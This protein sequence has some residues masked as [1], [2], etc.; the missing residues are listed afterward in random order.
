MIRFRCNCGKGLAVPD[1]AAGGD[2]QCP[3]CGRLQSVPELKDLPAI[4]ADGTW[5][6]ADDAAPTG[7]RRPIDVPSHYDPRGTDRHQSIEE[8][9]SVGLPR[10]APQKPRPKRY[11]PETGEL[12]CEF[13]LADPKD[14]TPPA[15]QSS[16]A[17]AA[18]AAVRSSAPASISASGFVATGPVRL[19]TPAFTPP[20]REPPPTLGYAAGRADYARLV[21]GQPPIPLNVRPVYWYTI[22]IELLQPANVLVLAFVFAIHIVIQ[23]LAVLTLFGMIPLII[24]AGWLWLVL[25]AHY[26]TVIDETGPER[27]DELPSVMRNLSPSEDFLRPLWGLVLALAICFGPAAAV[28]RRALI[29]ALDGLLYGAPAGGWSSPPSGAMASA[30][31]A[32]GIVGM[33]F[34]PAVLLTAATGGTYVNLAPHRTLGVIRAAPLKYAL[35]LA[36]LVAALISY[37]IALSAMGYLTLAIPSWV[38]STGRQKLVASMVGYPSL[39]IA[40]YC[41]HWF[42]WL[43]GKIHQEHLEEFGW[44]WQ[45]HISTR[46]D[47][48]KQLERQKVAQLMAERDEKVRQAAEQVQTRQPA[49]Q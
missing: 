22:P 8:I 12:I 38:P 37:P 23:L 14:W 17:P 35:T 21:A 10:E 16:E 45:R 19:E 2:V 48:I 27:R 36:V 29:W 3:S 4:E 5:R 40:V 34:F 6:F 41:A 46:H 7:L 42:A 11:D 39:F 1:G 44:V 28:S 24:L 31:L 43:L 30:G 13:D 18:P 15:A 25:L 49:R 9:L 47:A 32:L 33:V 26:V 20:P